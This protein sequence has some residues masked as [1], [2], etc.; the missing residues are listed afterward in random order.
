MNKTFNSLRAEYSAFNYN[1]YKIEKDDNFIKIEFDFSV[2]NLCSFKPETKIDI[3]NLHIVNDFSSPFAKKIIFNLGMVELISY[4]KSCCPKIVKIKCGH[5]DEEDKT[6]WK[7]LYF[8]G[9]GEF[10]YRNEIA[11]SFDDFMKITCEKEDEKADFDFINTG[12]NIIPVGGGKDSNVTME[13]LKKY[14]ED[15]YCFTVNNQGART[16]SAAAA[17]YDESKII[18]TFRTISPELLELNKKGFLNGHTPFSAIVAFLSFYCAYLIGA[19][20]IVLSNESSANESNIAGTQIN[21][22]Y[23]KSY[24][25]ETDFNNYCTKHFCKDIKYFSLLRTFNELQ[26]AKQFSAFKKYLP[27]FKSCNVG[28]KK[29][30]WCAE[31]PKCLFVYIILSPFLSEEE[32]TEIFA[33]NMLEKEHLK[34]MFDGLVGFSSVKPFECIGTNEEV[35]ASLCMLCENLDKENKE[36]P[37][38]LD[39]FAKNHKKNDYNRELLKHYNKENNIPEKFVEVTEEMYEYVSKNC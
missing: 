14:R 38:L 23:S 20:N 36:Y 19:E 2:D 32:L 10:F 35:I 9:L 28:S 27:V 8:G 4:W 5:L 15:N 18:K 29:N 7:S 21:H 34:G 13:L 3:S 6:W 11:V 33:C 16:E 24:Q 17:G 25:F 26:I 37:F 39:Y 1:G 22:Q 31:C 12:K 30:V